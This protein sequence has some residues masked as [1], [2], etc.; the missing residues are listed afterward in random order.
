MLI[1]RPQYIERLKSFQD[2][3]LIKVITGLRRSGK[4]TLFDLFIKDLRTHGV[5][6]SQIF[7][8]NFDDPSYEFDSAKDLYDYILKHIDARRKTYIFLDEVQLVPDF[9]KAVNGLRLKSNL[10]IYITGSNA[11]LLSGQLATLLSGR[12][13][14]IHMLPLS[15]REYLTGLY[16]QIK[17]VATLKRKIN[18][19]AAL[20]DYLNFGGLPQTIQH[21]SEHDGLMVPNATEINEYIENIFGTI[22]YKDA[23]LHGGITSRNLLERIIKFILDNI[24][25]PTSIK[26]I[27]DVLNTNTQKVNYRAVEN[28]ITA[29][30]ESFLIYRADRYDVRGRAL[31]ST[32]YKYFVSDLGLRSYLLGRNTSVDEGQ[33]LENVV[34][35]ELLRRRKQVRVGKYDNLEVDFV[36]SSNNENS[37]YQVSK[38]VAN[39]DILA[40]ELNSLQ[41]IADNYPKYLLTGD[42]S[43][44]NKDGIIGKTVTD[45]LLEDN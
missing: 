31:L 17:S 24:G 37:Y 9:Q 16:P 8:I 43:A 11:Y 26:K 14:E 5:E 20:K 1:Q 19:D 23:M 22:V 39:A 2:Q 28:C 32:G 4:S 25:Q 41:S 3:D 18:L 30:E 21:Y 12:Y 27:T 34:Y 10:D 29:L 38:S 15:F 40:R 7:R 44:I 6:Q 42:N 33:L 35:L 45:W 36:A 13:I